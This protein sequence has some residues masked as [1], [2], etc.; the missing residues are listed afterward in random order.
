LICANRLGHTITVLT[1]SG[2]SFASGFVRAAGLNPAAVV[3][4]NLNADGRPDL[5]TANSGG[6]SVSVLVNV[7][8]LKIN[9][10][11]AMAVVSWPAAW[12]NW[13]LQQKSNLTTGNWSPA[14]AAS[15]DGTNR[16][17][18]VSSGSGSLLF[19]LTYP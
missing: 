1:N 2:S 4:D 10:L 19:R 17:V 3:A 5:I 12:T 15:N 6:D 14:G 16:S 7:P 18:T 13:V 11:G 9:R 8:L